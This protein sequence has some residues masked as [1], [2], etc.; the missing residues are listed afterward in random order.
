MENRL[1]AEIVKLTN[2]I[3]SQNKSAASAKKGIE[4]L[5]YRMRLNLQEECSDRDQNSNW[6][7]SI[8]FVQEFDESLSIFFDLFIKLCHV[9]ALDGPGLVDLVLAFSKHDPIVTVRDIFSISQIVTNIEI[10]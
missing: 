6:D 10:I 9:D 3:R 8:I 4:L 1:V 2:N 7:F 5:T